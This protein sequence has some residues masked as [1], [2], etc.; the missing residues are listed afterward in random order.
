MSGPRRRLVRPG[1]RTLLGAVIGAATAALTMVLAGL[2]SDP[3]PSTALLVVMIAVVGLSL[4]AAAALYAYAA[5]ALVMIG[6]SAVPSSE[7]L[8]MTQ[9]LRI[10][11]FVIGSPLIVLLAIR[12]ERLSQSAI[13]ARDASEAS[14]RVAVEERRLAV[15]ARRDLDHALRIAQLE[16]A[17]LGN[18]AE[19]IPEPLIV[20]DADG[21]GTYANR[22]ALRLFGRA[23][24]ERPI[25]EWARMVEPRD[26]SRNPIPREEWPQ[27]AAQLE[28]LRRRM[29]LRL[30]T[31]GRDLLVDVEGTP[32]L[33]GGC[34]L[35]LRDVGKE[36]DARRRLSR[37][38]S[39]VAHE[40]RNPL[41]VAR[42]RMELALREPGLSPR[43]QGH[44]RRGLDSVEAAIAILER[45]EMYS[46]ADMG[47]LEAQR[48]PFAMA[49]AVD[50]ALER[51]RARGSEREV[52]IILDDQPRARGDAQLA[53]QA[54]TN[55]LINADRYSQA[56][57]PIDVE[58]VGGD[59]IVLRVTDAGPGIAD[60]VA[61]RIFHER[62]AASRGLGLGLYLVRA[63]MEAQGGSVQLE[64]RQPRA[65]FA[66]R[67][68]R[69]ADDLPEIS[70][71][72]DSRQ[73]AAT[74]QAHD[75]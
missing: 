10:G 2:S 17:S 30:P 11:S 4:G 66:L 45:L 23:F 33:G 5:A 73:E 24:V 20:Y 37:F 56:G 44:A 6:L 39:F 41:A 62:I 26:E 64:E 7:A 67:W 49:A 60:V 12:A 46:R 8:S 65:V 68:P 16:G 47:S 40:L 36:E 55:L 52:R 21:H 71:E 35:L 25:D 72:Q 27:V 13:A 1:I 15:A 18:V 70:L 69:A 48:E 43:V 61:E 28:P 34:V 9:L 22:A 74:T 50:E 31:S 14:E 63:M 29:T 75:G 42:G 57:A 54:I 58:I 3:V 19:A 59:P 51:F 38:A 32:V 53:G